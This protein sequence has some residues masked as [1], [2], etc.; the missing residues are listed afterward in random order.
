M[1][2]SK[3]GNQAHISSRAQEINAAVEAAVHPARVG[4]EPDT[5]ADDDRWRVAEEDF[6][7]G[8]DSAGR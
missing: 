2:G 3:Q 6:E 4:D 1:L 5:F 7:P 8:L